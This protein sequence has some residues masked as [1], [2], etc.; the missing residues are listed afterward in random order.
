[1]WTTLNCLRIG[2]NWT[3]C[4]SSDGISGYI[5]AATFFISWLNVRYCES[6]TNLW[7]SVLQGAVWVSSVTGTWQQLTACQSVSQSVTWHVFGGDV[8]V[9]SNPSPVYLPKREGISR[10]YVKISWKVNSQRT[11]QRAVKCVAW[12]TCMRPSSTS[13]P[14]VPQLVNNFPAFI[15]IGSSLPCSQKPVIVP[16]PEPAES[17]LAFDF[18]FSNIISILFSHVHLNLP[19]GLSSWFFYSTVLY[20]FSSY[21]Y[22]LHVPPILSSLI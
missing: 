20:V 13:M 17:S 19:S 8:V 10:T 15:E 16:Y 6:D 1:M 22:M 5:T 3:Y 7:Y 4:E 18:Y 12:N 21:P 14:L 9:I 2:S 11:F